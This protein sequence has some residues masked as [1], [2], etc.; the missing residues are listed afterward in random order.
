MTTPVNLVEIASRIRAKCQRESWYGPEDFRPK[1]QRE[2][3]GVKGFW[4]PP[5]TP[6]QI[7]LTEE[8]LGFKLPHA[9]VFLYTTLANG[10]FGPGAGLRG[11]VGGYGTRYTAV[12][13]GETFLNEESIAKYQYEHLVPLTPGSWQQQ[14]ETRILRLS[15]DCWPQGLFPICD[16]GD[17]QEVCLDK[18]GHVF[19]WYSSDDYGLY[20]VMDRAI[21]LENWL[22]TWITEDRV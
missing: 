7:E 18:D 14:G 1:Q 21:S 9:L 12:P 2:T 17:C 11:L 13:N 4:C 20:E 10:G 16:L 19:D 15:Y 8:I 22:F 3:W 5:A 6:G